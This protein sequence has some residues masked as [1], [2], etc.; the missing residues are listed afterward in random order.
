M[1]V[2]WPQELRTWGHMEEGLEGC[3]WRGMWR[4][5]WG[6]RVE[7]HADQGHTG[8]WQEGCFMEKP[9]DGS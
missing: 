5:G 4:R 8:L 1:G 9:F 3:A 6:A 2:P 7:G